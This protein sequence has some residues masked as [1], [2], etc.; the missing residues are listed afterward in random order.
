MTFLTRQE[1]T[2]ALQS[3][4]IDE[5]TSYKQR[6]LDFSEQFAVEMV[7]SFLIGN[8]DMNYELRPF[9]EYEHS[10]IYPDNQRI[11]IT[12]NQTNFEFAEK[13]GI[14]LIDTSLYQAPS[15]ILPDDAFYSNFDPL[16]DSPEEKI[17][18]VKPNT[19]PSKKIQKAIKSYIDKE[20]H[21][22]TI[23]NPEY[24]ESCGIITCSNGVIS[25][26][27]INNLYN[28][29]YNNDDTI[30]QIDY[31]SLTMSEA[32]TYLSNIQNFDQ[33]L[34]LNQERD[35]NK[36]D[37]N[38]IIKQLVLDIT[39]HNLVQRLH[40]RQISDTIV[41]RYNQAIDML[42]QIQ[43]GDISINLKKYDE[44]MAFQNNLNVRHGI[45]K[46]GLRNSY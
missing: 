42:K 26:G 35:F 13:Y 12:S 45:S 5:I 6:I 17:L 34:A 37:R 24:S 40:P 46:S 32:N 31:S 29:I 3:C 15:T 41:D 1:I 38:V 16:D 39:V 20:E 23:D 7:K 30:T 22:Q 8:Y 9:V 28:T 27:Y 10:V 33:Y 43:R 36:D 25:S 11:R 2:N 21:F 14:E 19:C 44:A 18:V 4:S